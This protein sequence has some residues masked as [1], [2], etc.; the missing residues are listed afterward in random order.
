M[1]NEE[2]YEEIMYAAHNL[3]IG[4]EVLDELEIRRKNYTGSN[5]NKLDNLVEVYYFFKKKL[6]TK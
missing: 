1:T 6:H 4:K 3:G 2:I 5:W